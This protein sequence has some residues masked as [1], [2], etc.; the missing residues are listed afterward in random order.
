MKVGWKE[1]M[2]IGLVDEWRCYLVGF[3]ESGRTKSGGKDLLEVF[4]SAKVAR[5]SYNTLFMQ[6]LVLL[7]AVGKWLGQSGTYKEVA[8][9]KKGFPNAAVG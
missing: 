6:Y 7:S 1:N 9:R 2:Y 8:Q 3:M 4:S 5:K